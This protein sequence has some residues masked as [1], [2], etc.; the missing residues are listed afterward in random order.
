MVVTEQVRDIAAFR[1]FVL[2]FLDGAEILEPPEVRDD[3]VAWL[4]G[5][6]ATS[7]GGPS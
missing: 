4:E 6:A 7:N 5:L 1:S 2:T 3:M